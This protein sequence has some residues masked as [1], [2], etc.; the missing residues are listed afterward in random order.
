MPNSFEQKKK[1]SLL[2]KC[3]LSLILSSSQR[4]KK[5]PSSPGLPHNF[6][7]SP[8]TPPRLRSGICPIIARGTAVK[9]AENHESARKG[10]AK[11][12]CESVPRLRMLPKT[13]RKGVVSVSHGCPF[14]RKAEAVIPGTWLYG[15]KVTLRVIPC[16]RL[17]RC[18]EMS[19]TGCWG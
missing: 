4:T 3:L 15:P 13:Q 1:L 18:P 17:W 7:R 10:S 14:C 5:F 9:S 8:R 12:D 19:Q 2:H 11:G 16:P 6:E